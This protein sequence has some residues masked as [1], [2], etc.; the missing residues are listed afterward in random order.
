MNFHQNMTNMLEPIFSWIKYIL[1]E[2]H[3]IGFITIVGFISTIVGFIK[4]VMKKSSMMYF[5]KY[6]YMF[7]NISSA[8]SLCK[9]AIN[10][11]EEITK[12]D[13]NQIILE[14][15][16]EYANELHVV[17]EAISPHKQQ[18]S[19]VSYSG[20]IG[21]CYKT[22][23][24]IVENNVKELDNYFC[25]VLETNSEICVPIIY[26]NHIYGVINSESEDKNYFSIQSRKMLEGLARAIA[27]N[28]YRLEW[29]KKP[30]YRSW[31]KLKKTP[32]YPYIKKSS[33][34]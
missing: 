25:A 17:A 5:K 28:L 33:H 18:Y 10:E 34:A 9:M 13:Y 24:T 6:D 2:P 31:D 29:S 4:T 3:L 7:S 16:T 8:K 27:H 20:L 30:M 15:V 11:I 26:D 1:T 21:S 14:L 19:I 32:R 12:T 23:K 22:R